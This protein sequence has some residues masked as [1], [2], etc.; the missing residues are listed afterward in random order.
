MNIVLPGTLSMIQ[1]D[2]DDWPYKLLYP[3]PIYKWLSQP[4]K[5]YKSFPLLLDHSYVTLIVIHPGLDMV[6]NS[7]LSNLLFPRYTQITQH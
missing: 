5:C 6:S 7:F 1:L 3:C 4:G 2:A